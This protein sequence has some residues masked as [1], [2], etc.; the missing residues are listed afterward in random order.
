MLPLTVLVTHESGRTASYDVEPGRTPL[1]RRRRRAVVCWSLYAGT[2]YVRRTL[3]LAGQ[4]N[5]ARRAHFGPYALAARL[6]ARPL[7]VQVRVSPGPPVA[8]AAM[9]RRARLAVW[10]LCRRAPL[11]EP[12][13]E[14]L[15]HWLC[16]C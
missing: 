14:R 10:L 13:R 1:R 16:Y 7:A 4:A 6:D 9:E 15:V 8:D 11:P 5:S 3:V 12:A 2:G